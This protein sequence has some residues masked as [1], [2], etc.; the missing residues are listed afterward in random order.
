L[1]IIARVKIDS[2]VSALQETR[3]VMAA[4]MPAKSKLIRAEAK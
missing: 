4:A 3:A 1:K 2:F